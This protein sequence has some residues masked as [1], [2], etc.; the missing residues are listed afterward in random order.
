[1][2][3]SVPV[4][5]NK[6]R[7]YTDL[8]YDYGPW[9]LVSRY[10]I[11][12]QAQKIIDQDVEILNLQMKVVE[13]YGEEFQNTPSDMIHIFI[14]SIRNEIEKGND[15]RLL[16]K[17]EYECEFWVW[18]DDYFR[19]ILSAD[20]VDFL[21]RSDAV[22]TERMERPEP[23]VRC[24]RAFDA[25][26]SRPCSTGSFSIFFTQYCNALAQRKSFD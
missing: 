4:S 5:Q 13:K 8:I 25:G 23:V 12:K 18:A 1:M 21:L 9:N 22:K 16:P 15:P 2:S 10:F 7:V 6:T 24:S 3:Q 14:E 17:K 20:A 19:S 11:K 26:G